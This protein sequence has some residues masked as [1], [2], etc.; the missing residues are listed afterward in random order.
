MENMKGHGR[1]EWKLKE[2]EGKWPETKGNVRKWND[3]TRKQE[4]RS[5]FWPLF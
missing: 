1:S 5:P 4:R 2:M 3:I